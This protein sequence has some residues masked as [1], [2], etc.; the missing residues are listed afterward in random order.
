MYADGTGW[1]AAVR[2]IT[3]GPDRLGSLHTGMGPAGPGALVENDE[4]HGLLRETLRV[5]LAAGS[6]YTATA[7]RLS[8]HK[9]TVQY[10]VGKAEEAL[11][12]PLHGREPDVELA[13]RVCRSLGAPIL[14]P[15]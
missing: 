7:E 12:R 10:R 1:R 14:Q 5:F 13:L 11:G 6:S 2:F 4:N 3:P 8:M 9:N 15:A